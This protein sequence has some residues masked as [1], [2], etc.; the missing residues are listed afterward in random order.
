V[1]AI[2]FAR[3]QLLTQAANIEPALNEDGSID[4]GATFENG[5]GD[6][7]KHCGGA[8]GGVCGVSWTVMGGAI[9]P[10]GGKGSV[11]FYADA[12]GDMAAYATVYG[13]AY[14]VP[15]VADYKVTGI[16]VAAARGAT[17]DNLSGAGGQLG[18]SS[19]L[20]GGPTVDW[21][22]GRADEGYWHGLSIGANGGAG[23]EAHLTV[24][25]S[26]PLYRSK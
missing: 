16:S 13:G 4:P 8:I 1:V 24:S 11:D 3:L 9:T 17:V 12:N 21:I 23:V 22:F 14:L 6:I 10:A 20:I 7:L 26:Q 18:A 19:K 15:T 2:K 25:Y 5:L